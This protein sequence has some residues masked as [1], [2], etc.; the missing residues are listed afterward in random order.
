[1]VVAWEPDTVVETEPRPTLIRRPLKVN[2]RAML[3]GA[4]RL[5]GRLRS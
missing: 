2:F 3:Q 1:L 4:E 5:R